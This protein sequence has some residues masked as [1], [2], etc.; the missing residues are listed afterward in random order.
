M[1]IDK[2]E[3]EMTPPLI[4][5]IQD[6]HSQAIKDRIERHKHQNNSEGKS[7]SG[8]LMLIVTL[9]I[10]CILFLC[11]LRRLFS[12]KR[13]TQKTETTTKSARNVKNGAPRA[14]DLKTV[15][16]IGNTYKDKIISHI[17]EEAELNEVNTTKQEDTELLVENEENP[18]EKSP[19]KKELGKINY[20]V[21]YDFNTST[22]I[23][24]MIQC[25][26][27]IAMDVGGSSD[28]YVKIYL[29]PDRKRKQET[30]VHRK[31]L[32]PTFNEVFKFEI[33]YGEVMGKTLVFA[34]YDFDRFSK[35]DQIGEV[36]LPICQMD[37]A[38]VQEKW[39]SLQSIVG[40]GVLGDICFSL[41]YVPNSGKLT[42]VIL[43]AKNLKK[44]DVGGLSDPYVKIA[45]MQN[46]KRIR[47][48][49]KPPSKI[50]FEHIQKVQLWVTV[51][52]GAELRHWSD[53]MATPRRP[54]AQWHTLKAI[55][56][57]G[58][59]SLVH[60]QIKD[61]EQSQ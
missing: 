60:Q 37:L 34:V 48:K 49:R 21:E 45:L 40:D 30:R 4:G 52:K 5:A 10:F 25:K 22:L 8:I 44:M 35:H 15:Q 55:E 47:K 11:Y 16:Q 17:G 46:D 13:N 14:G 33:S 51:A 6:S 53:M 24:T 12:K 58:F 29:L 27:L 32:N 2:R 56:G 28:P 36:R 57:R 31:T 61:K 41:R 18:D 3:T 7:Y 54:V 43:E 1:I 20:K 9:A 59:L 42:I 26:D 23:V 39:K 50:P 38:Q 19:K